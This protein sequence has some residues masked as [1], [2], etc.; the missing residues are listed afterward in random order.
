MTAAEVT[1]SSRRRCCLASPVTLHSKFSAPP[2]AVTYRRLTTSAA[3]S[4]TARSRWRC[5]YCSSDLL[6]F[7]ELLDESDDRLFWKILN[8][9]THT[10]HTLIPSQS[11]ASQHY[12]LRRR[13]HDR[14]LPTQTSH[15]CNKNFVTR[16][17]YKDIELVLLTCM[18]SLCCYVYSYVCILRYVSLLLKN[19]DDDDVRKN[20]CHAQVLRFFVRAIQYQF[21][22]IVLHTRSSRWS[23]SI[24][25]TPTS[26]G[27]WA[28]SLSSVFGL[29]VYF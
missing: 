7:E 25:R 4:V 3:S 11:I 22:K 15:L 18:Y 17:L 20:F 1:A 23:Y 24:Y 8:N 9:S 13:N 2:S 10:L 28:C 26:M 21:V 6:D 14:Q 16:A 12:P 5:G 19:D 27:D 29:S